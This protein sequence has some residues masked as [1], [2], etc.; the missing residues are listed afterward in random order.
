MYL[1]GSDQH[2]GWFHSTCWPRSARAGTRLQVGLDARLRGG[3]RRQEDEQVLGQ[4]HRA[5]EIIDKYGAEVLRL[6]VSAQDYKNDIRIS[7]EI[8]DRLVET[9]RKIR[10]RCA[11]CW[12]T[13]RTSIR[14]RIQWH[15]RTSG[16]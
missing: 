13:F 9:Y 4:H 10:T 3:R 6:W 11:S 15:I 8:I 7:N 16:A 12:E 14:P 1:E 5:P 2:R